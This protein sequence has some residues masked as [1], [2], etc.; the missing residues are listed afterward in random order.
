VLMHFATVALAVEWV[1]L[2]AT[3]ATFT[4]VNDFII[5]AGNAETQTS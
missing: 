4:R 1:A 3:L 2:N 5:H